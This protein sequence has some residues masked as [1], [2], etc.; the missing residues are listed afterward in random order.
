[1]ESAPST[2]FTRQWCACV[3][4]HGP[5]GGSLLHRPVIRKR[6][7]VPQP[8]KVPLVRNYPSNHPHCATAKAKRAKLCTGIG[9]IALKS[10]RRNSVISRVADCTRS[11][12]TTSSSNCSPPPRMPCRAS[13]RSPA[14]RLSQSGVACCSAWRCARLRAGWP[15]RTPG[16]TRSTSR[17][18]GATRPWP[19]LRR[20]DGA[21]GRG[22]VISR[23]HKP[24]TFQ[25]CGRASAGALVAR[26]NQDR[27]RHPA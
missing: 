10:L 25:T 24:W 19:T 2:C 18:G 23:C 20:C 11:S 8:Q 16:C 1:M 13:T 5:W 22:H 9:E 17:C 7:R 27:H 3:L 4:D 15:S 12:G 26:R 6:R 21:Q 14:S